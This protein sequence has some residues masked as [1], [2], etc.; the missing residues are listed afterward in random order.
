MRGLLLLFNQA[1][2]IPP[3]EQISLQIR[4]LIASAQLAPGTLLPSVRQLAR[5]LG[6]AQNTVVRAYNE[7]EHGGWVVTSERKGVMV[8]PH[9]PILT[10]EQRQQRLEQAISELLVTAH[11]LGV[12]AENIHAEVDR[13]WKRF[14]LLEMSGETSSTHFAAQKEYQTEV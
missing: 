1:S 13:Q 12:S 6:V 7:L 2:P 9:P 8:A 11:Q 5:D 3:Y 4:T 14:A 10:E